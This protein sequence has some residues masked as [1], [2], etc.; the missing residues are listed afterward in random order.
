MQP[1]FWDF[2]NKLFDSFYKTKEELGEENSHNLSDFY[3]KI[4]E[5]FALE[6]GKFDDEKIAQ[7]A[8]ELEGKNLPITYDPK[9]KTKVKIQR[10]QE[11][12]ERLKT[13]Q[14]FIFYA[15]CSF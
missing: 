6:S 13:N 8:K 7:M 10:I 12:N 4:K 15:R 11:E 1:F 9:E 14:I 5:N 3:N 2:S